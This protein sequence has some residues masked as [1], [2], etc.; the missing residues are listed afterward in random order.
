MFSSK[1]YIP[2]LKWKRGEYRALKGLRDKDKHDITPLI[3]LVMPT[4]QLYKD[5]KKTVKKSAEEM[6]KEMVI[7]FEEK[8]ILEIPKE[9]LT[10][11]GNQPIFVDF[12]LIYGTQPAIHLKIKALKSI[13]LAGISMGLKIIPVL[14][15]N[16][17]LEFKQ[18]LCSLSGKNNLGICLRV[19]S[20]D[21]SDMANIK[22]L[23]D[24]IKNFLLIF[25]LNEKNIDLLI[26]IK[27]K[28]DQYSKY[29]NASQTI[30]NLIKWRNFIFASGAF[31]ENLNG[32]KL[33]EQTLLPRMDWQEWV[34]HKKNKKLQRNPIFADYTIRNPIFIESLQYHSSTTSIK[35]TLE[36]DWLVMKGK[37][38][39]YPLYLV[40]AKLLVEDT[41]YFYG[42][43]FSSGDQYLA[44]KAKH[45]YKY[46]KNPSIK[47]TG[48]SEDWIAM[49]ISHHL[50]L[51]VSQMANLS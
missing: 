50:A 19:T 1:H 5:K 6:I 9:I 16:E 12:S 35:Y 42:E 24:K 10:S 29:I 28:N 3:E 21:L 7:K 31:P 23:N 14:N 22:T 30:M 48:R 11:W 15:L 13:I 26:D 43:N 25:N 40:N 41:K 45:Y 27:E 39:D 46:I 34:E 8:R 36:N 32:C 37:K 20:S 4:V 47:G 49:G 2:I 44:Q 17:E 38:L 18:E 51:V 33:D